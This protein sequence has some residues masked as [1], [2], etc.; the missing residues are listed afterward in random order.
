M[1]LVLFLCK[2]FLSFHISLSLLGHRKRDAMIA[3]L[4]GADVFFDN[5][6]GIVQNFCDACDGC[7]NVS[8]TKKKHTVKNPI[9]TTYPLEHIQLD[10]VELTQDA[11]GNKYGSNLIDCFSKFAHGVRMDFLS[12]LPPLTFLTSPGLSSCV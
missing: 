3:H 12:C 7:Q 4:K 5:L 2:L 1:N 9:V 6:R 11:D 8:L 10:C